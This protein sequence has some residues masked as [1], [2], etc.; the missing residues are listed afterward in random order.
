MRTLITILLFSL[1]LACTGQKWKPEVL[2]LSLVYVS[3]ASKGTADYLQFHY[4]GNNQFLNPDLSWRNKWKNGDPAQ[5]EAF[6]GSSTIFVS[7]TDGWHLCNTVNKYTCIA[8]IVIRINHKQPAIHYLYDF[9]AFTL[10][11]SAGFWTTYELILK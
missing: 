8:A 2:P 1:S 10:A 7:F 9:L 4:S 11:Y 3:G 6:P 5:G